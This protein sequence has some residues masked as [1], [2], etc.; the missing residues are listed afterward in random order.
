MFIV[1]SLANLQFLYCKKG[2]QS[3]IYYRF[4][5]QMSEW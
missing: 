2:Q 5:V 4:L 1:D 3:D